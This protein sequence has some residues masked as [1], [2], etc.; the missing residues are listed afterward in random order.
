MFNKRILAIIK[1]IVLLLALVLLASCTIGEK[2]V[3]V[4]E[5]PLPEDIDPGTV[6]IVGTVW[7]VT[8][9]S[10]E[11]SSDNTSVTT[12][13]AVM[14]AIFT[15]QTTGTTLTIP[16][17]WD[18]GNVYRVRFAPTEYG[19]WKYETFCEDDQALAGKIGTIGANAYK[20]DLAVY[21]HGFVKTESGKKFFV[22]D[23]G[24]PFF[25]LGD[26]HWGMYTEE[27]D[28]KGDRAG[29]IETDSHFKYVVDTRVDQGFTVYQSEPLDAPFGL[30]TSG[31]ITE[32]AVEG[33]KQADRYYQYIAEKGLV[34]ANAE[35]FFTGYMT[36]ALAND[37]EKLEYLSRYWVARF[38]AYPVMWTLAQEC[39]NDFYYE[40]GEQKIYGKD[41]NPWVK[42]A[43]FITK[44]DAYKHPLSA[45]QENVVYTTVTGRGTDPAV[46]RDYYGRS[47]FCGLS[48][49]YGH[50]W[51]AAQWSPSLDCQYYMEVPKDYWESP[52]VA[53][54]YEGRYAYL[55]TK[56]FGSRAQGWISFLS[57]MYGYGYGAA[58]L[59]R[60]KSTYNM[61]SESSDGIET[62]TVED[63]NML[64]SEAITL[65]SAYQM[66]YMKSFLETFDWWNLVPDFDSGEHFTADSGVY[67]AVATAGDRVVIY[68][69]DKTTN[70]G[71]VK[72]L[73][74]GTY[75]V[76]W[77]NPSTGEYLDKKTVKV[78]SEGTIKLERPTCDDWVVSVSK[79]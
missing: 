52:K 33:F 29:N 54:N 41:T 75:N 51:W 35:F 24:T 48:E 5:T 39:D 77:Y 76:S 13:K 30:L 19:V 64:W 78:T 21:K 20:G 67:F 3:T 26:T 60:Y 40:R 17:F 46:K 63:K 2:D 79:K 55:W 11:G 66:G 28:E 27:F 9:L 56:D 1:I 14:D 68:L 49:E 38:G 58:D 23:D 73:S 36:E 47:A 45:H 15:N 25:Y 32:T 43:K 12:G 59:W 6:D 37:D 61:D 18:G 62:I 10:F 44:Y 50:N 22:Y 4:K 8:E 53:I 34:H 7:N 57:G 74:K 70:S 16:S 71:T 42:I 65:P 72:G 31:V 69:Y